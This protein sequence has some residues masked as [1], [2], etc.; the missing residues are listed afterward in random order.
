MKNEKAKA[1]PAIVWEKG[2]CP[3]ELAGSIGGS[4]IIPL[5]FPRS[6][7]PRGLQSA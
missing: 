4:S 5:S 3:C 2:D 6:A 1:A 7:E